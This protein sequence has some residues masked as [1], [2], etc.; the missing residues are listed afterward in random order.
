MLTHMHGW[1]GVECRLA[2]SDNGLGFTELQCVHDRHLDV[3]AYTRV[4][5]VGGVPGG[6]PL[7]D[8]VL[9]KVLD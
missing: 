9:G 4:L 1:A 8:L 7:D 6:Y 3:E 2:F 5:R